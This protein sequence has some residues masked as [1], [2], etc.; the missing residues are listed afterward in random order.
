[1]TDNAALTKVDLEQAVRTVGE[2]RNDLL[3][4]HVFTGERGASNVQPAPD[5]V[6]GA[7]SNAGALEPLY[8]P[9][10]LVTLLENSNALRQ[11]VDA[12]AT[13][14]DAFGHRF[15][16][17]VDLDAADATERLRDYIMAK[18]EAADPEDLK[19]P[20]VQIAEPTDEEVEAAKKELAERMRAEAHELKHFFDFACI[21]ISFVMLRRQ[22]REDVETLGNGY[23][24]VSRDDSGQLTGFEYIPGFTIRHLPLDKVPTEIEMRVKRN[25][26]DFDT[27]RVR[28]RFRRYIQVFESDVIYFKEFGDPRLISKLT[29]RVHRDEKEMLSSNS[30]DGPATEVIHFKVHTSKSS[31]GVPRWIGT[32]LSVLGSRQAEEVNYLYFE[33]KSV[34][35]MALL[36]SGGRISSTTVD[37]IKDFIENDIKGKK[38]FHKMLVLEAESSGTGAG[39]ENNGRMKIDLKPLTGAQHNDA[40]FQDYDERNIDKVGMSFRLPRML[41]GDIR[42]FNRATAEAALEFAEM[43]VFAPERDAFDFVMNRKI[44][45]AL[46]IRFHEFKSNAPNTRNAKDL[47]DMVTEQVHEGIMTPAEARDMAPAVFN[48]A[49]RKIKAPWTRQ[50]ISMT[51]AGIAP[52]EDFT[53]GTEVAPGNA[54]GGSA[55][56]GASIP[57]VPTVEPTNGI[58]LTGTDLASIVTVNEARSESGLGHLQLP[59]PGNGDDPDGFLTVAEFKAKKM[60]TGTTQGTAEGTAAGSAGLAGV[61]GLGPDDA[62]KDDV[63]TGDLAT[64]GGLL[65]SGQPKKF[66]HLPPGITSSKSALYEFATNLIG[67]RKAVALADEAEAEAAFAKALEDS[68]AA[69]E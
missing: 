58:K 18:R 28:K 60:A 3:K 52:P 35:P 50:P 40:L 46:G 15:E 53:P 13:N 31:Y 62:T 41:R 36:V 30:Q 37:R 39:F 4:A 21:D 45:P 56:N 24:E 33:N 54:L 14:I 23:W 65:T 69:E 17:I 64:G 12:Y 51:L 66:R 49:L 38:N 20:D 19:D 1:M 26:F 44:L 63:G 27:V 55:M 8:N 22:T 2:E 67:M 61:P 29:G 7:Y 57:G 68:A 43:Q 25:Q 11:N 59:P 5:E 42:D 16:P 32:L 48:R 47:N 9:H 10:T 6:L 34:P